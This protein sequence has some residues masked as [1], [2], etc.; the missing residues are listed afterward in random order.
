V[1]RIES[2]NPN[3]SGPGA[4]GKTDDALREAYRM[5]WWKQP[6]PFRFEHGEK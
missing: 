6:L 2:S 5:A 4:L 1:V 3:Q